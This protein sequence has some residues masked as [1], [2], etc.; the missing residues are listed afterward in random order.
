MSGGSGDSGGGFLLELFREEARTHTGVLAQGLV[1]LEQDPGDPTKIEPLMRAAHSV[2]GAAR[3]VR[4]EPAV[5]LAH[6]MEDLLVAAQHGRLRLESAHIDLLLEGT[7]RLLEIAEATAQAFD[8]W[9]A[10]NGPA[11]A[12]ITERLERAA[13]GEFTP[14]A[15]PAPAA[16]AA[17][18]APVSPPPAPVSSAPPPVAAAVQPVA[19]SPVAAPSVSVP[20]SAA[21]Q[22]STGGE[23]FPTIAVSIDTE[24]MSTVDPA[25]LELFRDEVHSGYAV[26]SEGL[27]RVEQLAG[28]PQAI[29]PLMRAAHSIKGAARIVA[30][31]MVV[32]IAHALEDCLV[33]AQKG[34]VKLGADDVDLL[35]SGADLL[36]RLAATSAGDVAGE[37]AAAENF[38]TRVTR[39]AQGGPAASPSLAASAPAPAPA[40]APGPAPAATAPAPV[41]LSTPAAATPAESPVA[42]A[43]TPSAT[44]ATVESAASSAPAAGSASAVSS[45]AGSAS[46]VSSASAANPESAPIAARDRSPTTVASAPA[47]APITSAPSVSSS[48]P[49]S[50]TPARGGGRAAGSAGGAGSGAGNGSGNGAGSGGGDGGHGDAE[51]RQ[52]VVRVTAQSLTRLMSLAGESLVEARWLGPF[53]ASLL[54]LKKMH[55]H[56]ASSLDAVA[57]ATTGTGAAPAVADARRRLAECRQQLAA[58]MD[59]FE[60][61]ARQTADLN[62]RLYH[63]VIDSRMRPFADG[64]QGFPRLVRDLGRQ[65]GKKVQFEIIGSATPVD[66]DIL[67]QLEAP[68]NHLLRNAM[69]H[70]VETPDER[71]A[72]GK[73]ESAQL[74]LHAR[75]RAGM[76]MITVSDDGRGISEEKLRRK[77]VARGLSTAELVEGMTQRELF[78]FLFLPGFSTAE[79]VTEVSGRGVGL[80]VVHSMV[81]AVGGNVRITSDLGRGTTFHLQLPITLSVIRAV[82]ADIGGE[83]YAF[84]QNRLERLLRVSRDELRS[85]EGRQYLTVD[86]RNVGTVA[87]HQ[88]LELEAAGGDATGD[89][90]DE[91][92]IILLGDETR[93]FGLVVDR[94]RGEQD[95]VVRT[96]DP[97]LG[98]VPHVS[99]AALM[100]DGAPVLIVDVEDLLRGIDQVLNEGRLRR[101]SRRQREEKVAKRILIVDDS[102]TVREVQRQLLKSHGYDV[103]T[104]VDGVD[105][106]HS[107]QADDYDLVIS[108]VDMPRMN[109]F[110]FVKTIKSDERYRRLPVIIVSYKDRPEDRMRGL[111]AGANYYLTKSSFHDATFLETVVEL[112]GA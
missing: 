29:E 43:A 83:P 92:S 72:A 105:G 14:A 1:E 102:I 53:G 33:A 109:G 56:L 44:V 104:A 93:P 76:L 40:P 99:A 57:H 25:L 7:D 101:L 106:W 89:G 52:R 63:E 51:A 70:G 85:I 82:L 91:L 22:P 95:L 88:I 26:L 24:A 71:A 96:L 31:P 78:D 12:H 111:E 23:A 110:E 108:D 74:R 49:A 54:K 107:L 59:E 61:H 45:T 84:P 2:K 19:A 47:S 32:Q 35:L 55:D 81:Q 69:D 16:A 103:S 64:V 18:P 98:R 27:V 90:S 41:S 8:P 17:P 73:P 75:H 34:R 5:R 77:I 86:G 9:I 94:F 60:A 13:K 21:P 6:I 4:I 87:A 97:R 38:V 112:I 36:Q 46:A 67:E 42:A 58:R 37:Q 65:L 62:S 79:K 20:S 3:I 48:T 50:G 30:F 10:D 80:D 66:R 28:D 15:P 68:L 39:L 11:L 100:D